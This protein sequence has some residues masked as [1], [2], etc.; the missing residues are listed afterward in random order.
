[1][2]LIIW[3]ALELKLIK[4][5]N[6]F[7]REASLPSA[8]GLTGGTPRQ[9]NKYRAQAYS[10]QRRLLNVHE[11]ES[12]PTLCKFILIGITTKTLHYD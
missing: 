5:T 4:N 9:Y 2:I 10:W 7:F 1:M 12:R 6:D 3:S 8:L 11:H